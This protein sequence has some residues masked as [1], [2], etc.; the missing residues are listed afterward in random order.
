MKRQNVVSLMVLKV[1]FTT[2]NYT[3]MPN[4]KKV[5][6][7]LFLK[8]KNPPKNVK[9]EGLPE[10]VVPLKR[11]GETIVCA[12]PNGKHT[13][14]FR[15]Q[16]SVLLNFGMS[17]Y[18]SQGRT[19]PNNVIDLQNC[20]THQSFYTALSRSASAEGTII[21]QGFEQSK[22]QNAGNLSGHLRQEFRELELLNE[23]TKLRYENKLP[24]SVNAK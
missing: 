9:L 6:T 20:K 12:M 21:V 23:I 16:I 3:V 15:E 24:D 13:K 17:D 5:L 2:E 19:R 7:V 18:S 1:Q 4:K 11:N 22:I 10:N 14:V 8:L